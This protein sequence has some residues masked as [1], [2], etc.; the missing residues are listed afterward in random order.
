MAQVRLQAL[1]VG[2]AL[3]E[4]MHGVAVP[5]H[6]RR[7]R[8]HQVNSPPPQSPFRL[9][10]P[11]A[12]GL[13]RHG[14]DRGAPRQLEGAQVLAGQLGVLRI[15]QRHQAFDGLPC[16]G[17]ALAAP[18]LLQGAQRH[19]RPLAIELEIPWGQ[20]QGLVDAGACVPQGGHQEPA[21]Q[22]R[23]HGQHRAHFV[24]QEITGRVGVG[25]GEVTQCRGHAP[26]FGAAGGAHQGAA[27]VQGG[28]G[29]A[30]AKRGDLHRDPRRGGEVGDRQ[31]AR[32]GGVLSGP[33][34]PRWPG[35]GLGVLP[36]NAKSQKRGGSQEGGGAGQILARST[37]YSGTGQLQKHNI[38]W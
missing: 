19:K 8:H 1:D 21:L 14:P 13:V 26:L 17:P 10:Q 3:K 32:S 29:V 24:R 16:P 20:R 27:L 31:D 33:I 18:A 38:L 37:R 28:Q 12:H 25:D 2:I 36:D 34:N 5:E 6:M 23:Q 4:V 15:E 35:A 9:A 7:Q 11:V 22:I 30:M